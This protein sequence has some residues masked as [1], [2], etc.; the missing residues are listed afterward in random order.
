[1]FFLTNK[2]IYLINSICILALIL[3]YFSPYLNPEFFWPIS[4]F[5]FIFPLLYIL[6]II[7]LLYWIINIEKYM[8]V[9]IIVL[10]FGIQHIDKFIGNNI[11][12]NQKNSTK[13]LTY[14][15]RLLNKYKWIKEN[16]IE[17]KIYDFLN[18]ENADI[19]CM[20][21][22]LNQNIQSKTNYEFKNYNAKRNDRSNLA[23][24]SKFPH[25]NLVNYISKDLSKV[26]IYSDL[27]V[28]S[29]T[30]RV[31]N[32]HLASNW[33][34]KSDYMFIKDPKI[35]DP[36][37]RKSILNI[38][39]KMKKAYVKRSKQ[40]IEIKKHMESS[41]FPVIICGDFND[42]PLSFSYNTLKEG[43]VDS[44]SKSGKGIGVSFNKVF[45]LRIDY[46]LHDPIFNTYNYKSYKNKL[47]DHYAVSCNFKIN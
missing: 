36:E 35:N 25:I 8:I 17:N 22:Y 33:F 29:D 23:I 15:V 46:I 28:N 21:E 18:K 14:N 2:I 7:F 45:G 19:L 41:K 5:G 47:S 6:N 34:T 40:V 4:F 31:Y 12:E 44:F 30:I 42:T 13:I 16:D 43:L 20:Q 39:K 9:N 1:M 3:S 10:I 11:Q 24:Y 38:I 26:C 37:S 27:V 32:I